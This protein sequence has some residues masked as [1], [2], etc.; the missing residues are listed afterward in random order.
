MP[1]PNQALSK[2]NLFLPLSLWMENQAVI[3]AAPVQSVEGRQQCGPLAFILIKTEIWCSVKA[4]ERR[5]LRVKLQ[6]TPVFNMLGL[7]P[8]KSRSPLQSV[9]KI[10]LKVIAESA[11]VTNQSKSIWLLLPLLSQLHTSQIRLYYFKLL[12]DVQFWFP[13]FT[14]ELQKLR[15]NVVLESMSPAN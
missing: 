2:S 6:F 3:W 11:E 5:C 7:Y 15:K 9:Q 12:C 14:T 13:R 4:R 10:E 1:L 8:E